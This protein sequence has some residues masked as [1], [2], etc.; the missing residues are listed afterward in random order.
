VLTVWT[1]SPSSRR[2]SGRFD[3]GGK[4]FRT[5]IN[6]WQPLEGT[7]VVFGGLSGQEMPR[8][9][10]ASP[11]TAPGAMPSERRANGA[12]RAVFGALASK[13]GGVASGAARLT[14]RRPAGGAAF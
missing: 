4:A 13:K 10:L 3:L 2:G 11:C 5:R 8:A 1:Q 7:N 12:G 14:L 6:C 9:W